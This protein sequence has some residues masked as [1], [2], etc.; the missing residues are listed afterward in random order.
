MIG[1]RLH[2]YSLGEIRWLEALAARVTADASTAE[3]TGAE[4]SSPTTTGGDVAANAETVGDAAV[5]S[6]LELEA[7]IQA[8]V[9]EDDTIELGSDPEGL[10]LDAELAKLGRAANRLHGAVRQRLSKAHGIDFSQALARFQDP[11]DADA[12]QAE[13]AALTSGQS[14]PPWLKLLAATM[15]LDSGAQTRDGLRTVGMRLE[16][17][18]Q[19]EG[20]Y[21]AVDVE[22]G[23]RGR[24]P[25][26]GLVEQIHLGLSFAHEVWTGLTMLGTAGREGAWALNEEE[27]ETREFTVKERETLEAAR[28]IERALD[29]ARREY[30]RTHDRTA[31][32]IAQASMAADSLAG[33]GQTVRAAAGWPEGAEAPDARNPEDISRIA[34]VAEA[35]CAEIRSI[36]NHFIAGGIASTSP[37]RESRRDTSAATADPGT[38]LRPV[39]DV[40]N[41]GRPD[42]SPQVAP[43]SGPAER[44]ARSI[45]AGGRRATPSNEA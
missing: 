5:T 10:A 26:T 7:R 25:L 27:A 37:N 34:T 40:E 38:D 11:E 3:R 33:A 28:R 20:G 9:E 41:D 44:N 39:P 2:A 12:A 29:R 42:P 31:D 17:E 8:A 35:L 30:A 24:L 22:T 32:T 16:L 21:A 13:I 43:E 36:A 1:H 18:E 19:P 15:L 23:A 14:A 4:V 6:M 45:A